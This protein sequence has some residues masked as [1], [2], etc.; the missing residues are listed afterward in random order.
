MTEN[1]LKIRGIVYKILFDNDK[2]YYGST[3][4]SLKCRFSLHKSSSK[5]CKT[6][7]YKEMNDQPCFIF[8]IE[9]VEISDGIR[10]LLRYKEG[11]LIKENIND[12]LCLN[13]RVSYGVHINRT[14]ENKNC[15]REY[16]KLYYQIKKLT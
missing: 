8:P 2:Y 4:L 15:K 14:N 7:L 9:Y 6:D 1:R 16:D 10:D 12:P 13:K 3:K 11:L 5:W